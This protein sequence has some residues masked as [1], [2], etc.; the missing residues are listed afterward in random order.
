M[1]VTSR[2]LLGLTLAMLF[3]SLAY[4]IAPVKSANALDASDKPAIEKIIK[5]YLMENPEIIRDALQELERRVAEQEKQRQKKLITENKELLLNEKYSFSAGKKDADITEV[6]IFDYN[7][8][9]C[10]QAVKDILKLMEEDKNVHVVLKEY[11]IL[12]EASNKA[13]LAALAARKQNKYLEYHQ[14]LLSAKGRITEK[15]IFKIAGDVGLDIDQMKKDMESEEVKDALQKNIDVGIA[16]GI[17]GTPTFIFNEHVIPQVLPYAAMKQ[18]IA[19][20]RK[21]S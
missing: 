18:L 11:P 13:A 10:R 1:S 7:C 19:K 8:P 5:D 12:G 20:L 9:Y 3:T 16:L 2:K 4:I 6:E 21:A 14:A 15:T 17:N